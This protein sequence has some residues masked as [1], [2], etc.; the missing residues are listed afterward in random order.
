MSVDG[1]LQTAD[2]GDLQSGSS[3]NQSA[4]FA[5]DAP[6][7]N[8]GAGALY[9][10]VFSHLNKLDRYTYRLSTK[11]VIHTTFNQIFCFDSECHV[12]K[13]QKNFA[14]EIFLTFNQIIIVL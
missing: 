7:G 8:G 11:G 3:T 12:C 5:D 4:A 14:S 6:D 1:S 2:T 9:V 13:G 10:D